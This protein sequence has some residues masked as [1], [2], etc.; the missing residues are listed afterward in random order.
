MTE[1][2][3]FTRYL[4]AKRSVDDRALNRGVW[5][6]LRAELQRPVADLPLEVL[7]IGGG[8]G[9]MLTRLLES[10]VLTR[11]NYRLVDIDPENV[12]RAPQ[13]LAAWAAGAGWLMDVHSASELKLWQGKYEV[14]VTLET[15]DVYG[16]ERHPS[17]GCDVLIANALMDLLDLSRAVP[18]VRDLVRPGG[19]LYLTINYDGQTIFEPVIQDELDETIHRLYNQTMDARLTNGQPSGDSR[20]GRHLFAALRQ[21]GILPLAAGSS[22]WV[23]FAG[24]DGYPADEEYFLRFI[25]HTVEQALL[26]QPEL[27]ARALTK[28]VAARMGQIERGELVYIAHQID[29]LGRYPAK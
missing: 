14:R 19:L 6:S 9:T 25:V 7:E 5:D 18:A 26:G 4:E 8:V 13:Y 12:Q 20:T 15:A 28:W 2:F 11:A 1:P 29:I 16:L 21:A 23:V 3:S 22:D 27:D 17:E 24:P 10:S